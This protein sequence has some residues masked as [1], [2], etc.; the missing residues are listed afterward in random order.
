MNILKQMNVILVVL[1]LVVNLVMA[2][3]ARADRIAK[4]SPDYPVVVQALDDLAQVK[5]DPKQ[6]QY[7]PDELQRQITNLQIQKYIL[8]TSKHWATC[9][10]QTGK[11]VAILAHA[12]KRATAS[13]VYYLADGQATDDDWDCDGVYLPAGSKISGLDVP[14]M[15]PTV[16]NPL[17]G[18]QLI[19][20]T[21]PETQATEVNLPLILTKVVKAADLNGALPVLAQADIE[22]QVPNAPVD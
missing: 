5:A 20:N 9:H 14:V 8:E 7:K 6:T 10:N 19:L 16:L 21:N 12:P 1:M 3:P 17:D 22:A 15:E 13:T 2:Q 4:K 11:T 18:T